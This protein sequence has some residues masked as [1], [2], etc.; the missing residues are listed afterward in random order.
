MTLVPVGAI[1]VDASFNGSV[2]ID[3]TLTGDASGNNSKNKSLSDSQSLTQQRTDAN[4]NLSDSNTATVDV[5]VT[6]TEST[7]LLQK[8]E[9]ETNGNTYLTEDNG[10]VSGNPHITKIYFE[11]TDFNNGPDPGGIWYEPNNDYAAHSVWT[12]GTNPYS[13][14]TL[15]GDLRIPDN[16]YDMYIEVRGGYEGNAPYAEIHGNPQQIANGSINIS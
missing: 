11:T 16:N 8:W 15:T 10:G 4:I 1:D 9:P 2:S 7:S 13:T 5:D 6:V 3:V 14:Y 12:T